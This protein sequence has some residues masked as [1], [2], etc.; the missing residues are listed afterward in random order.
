MNWGGWNSYKMATAVGGDLPWLPAEM[1]RRKWRHGTRCHL[2]LCLIFAL[3]L[4][5]NQF[6]VP[7]DVKEQSD[8]TVETNCYLSESHLQQSP[9]I[10]LSIV[11][12][13]VLATA[14]PEAKASKQGEAW[15]RFTAAMRTP[16][17]TWKSATLKLI[18]GQR[19]CTYVPEPD[20]QDRAPRC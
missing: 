14:R 15:P 2:L 16:K 19:I 4:R 13:M 12:K 17:N 9:D 6:L 8:D 5:N 11:S 18:S 20:L 7:V 10:T 1:D 3:L